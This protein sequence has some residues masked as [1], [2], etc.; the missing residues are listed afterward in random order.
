MKKTVKIY[1][2]LAAGLALTVFARG[3]PRTYET[4]GA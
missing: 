4:L 3:S 1:L 2:L